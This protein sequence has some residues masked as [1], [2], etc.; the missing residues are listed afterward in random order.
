MCGVVSVVWVEVSWVGCGVYH[1]RDASLLFLPTPFCHL[2]SLTPISPSLPPS[3]ILGCSRSTD[4]RGIPIRRLAV[5]QKQPG[6][7][8]SSTSSGFRW[9][10]SSFC[11]LAPGTMDTEHTYSTR[12]SF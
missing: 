6:C 2:C 4:E 12:S 5:Y 10:L 3:I 9:K 1:L 11:P 8:C 7:S